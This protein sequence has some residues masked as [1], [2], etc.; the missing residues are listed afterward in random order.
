MTPRRVSTIFSFQKFQEKG[1]LMP[2]L[3]RSCVA[4]QIARFPES[5]SVGCADIIF[6]VTSL[7]C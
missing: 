1:K 5:R 7:Y 3:K 4:N 2:F 6:S